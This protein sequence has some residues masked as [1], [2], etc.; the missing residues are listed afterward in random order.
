MLF[1]W[2]RFL[3]SRKPVMGT[4]Y[5]F[6]TATQYPIGF[7]QFINSTVLHTNTEELKI[8]GRWKRWGKWEKENKRCG[9]RTPRRAYWKRGNNFLATASPTYYYLHLFGKAS[10]SPCNLKARLVLAKKVN[11]PSQTHIHI[12][13]HIHPSWEPFGVSDFSTPE[14]RVSVCL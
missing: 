6:C 1:S 14:K 4:F 5:Y 2:P 7:F 9:I 10:S 11:A 8:T 12:H 3:P 13:T